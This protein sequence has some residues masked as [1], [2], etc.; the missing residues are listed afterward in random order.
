MLEEVRLVEKVTTREAE[1]VIVGL[2]PGLQNLNLALLIKKHLEENGKG[3]IILR[4][5]ELSPEPHS[6]PAE[7]RGVSTRLVPELRSTMQQSL[8]SLL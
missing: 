4:I 5:K 1:R 3:A 6:N 2:K 8:V 7:C